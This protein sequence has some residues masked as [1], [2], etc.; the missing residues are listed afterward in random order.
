MRGWT[1]G[2]QTSPEED[3]EGIL[4]A[5]GRGGRGSCRGKYLVTELRGTLDAAGT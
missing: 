2:A 5:L 4:Q 3:K 1:A